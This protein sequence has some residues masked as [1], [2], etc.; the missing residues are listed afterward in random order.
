[1]SRKIYNYFQTTAN[2]NDS[3]SYSNESDNFNEVASYKN[4]SEMQIHEYENILR[5]HKSLKSVAKIILLDRKGSGSVVW[6]YFG[7]LSVKGK[8]IFEKFRFCKLCFELELTKLK[9]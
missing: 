4:P 2:E 7:V 3:N 1:M 6:D 5:K 9:G 8:T